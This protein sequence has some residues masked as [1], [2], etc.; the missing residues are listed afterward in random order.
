MLRPARSHRRAGF[1]LVELMI[2]I[3]III[4]LAAILVVAIGNSGTHAREEATAALIRKVSNQVQERLEALDRLR[5]QPQWTNVDAPNYQRTQQNQ[6]NMITVE[7]AKI[8]LLK[9]R[10]KELFPQSFKELQNLDNFDWLNNEY[11]RFTANY[12]A[13]KHVAETESS[14]LLYY[15]LTSGRVPGIPTVDPGEYKASEVA[16]TDGD[17]LLEFVDAWGKPLRFYRW[18]TRLIRPGNTSDDY[19]T[20]A[21][22]PDRNSANVLI[23]GLPASATPDPLMKDQDDPTFQ[24]LPANPMAAKTFEGNWHTPQTYHVFLLA[25]AG[26]DGQKAGLGNMDDAFGLFKP[27][28]TDSFGYLA[29]PISGRFDALTDNITNRNR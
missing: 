17:G 9:L 25:S 11:A 3:G 20:P 4:F 2:V 5:S 21:I 1:T 12:N 23:S 18:P 27:T 26:A 22:L 24:L 16:D 14:A 7:Q 6:G 10:M 29:Q 8:L 15:E 28:D 19:E 13:S